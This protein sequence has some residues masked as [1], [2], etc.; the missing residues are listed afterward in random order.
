VVGRSILLFGGSGQVGLELRDLRWADDVTLVAP[1][2]TEADIT[3]GPTVSAL[4]A[5][6]PWTAV[7]NAAAWTAVDA[8][9][10]AAADAFAANAVGPAI[11]ADATRRHGVPL[12]H[13]S[14]DYVFDGRKSGAYE[15]DDRTAPLGVYGASKL[16]G[17][18]AVRTGNPRHVIV[19][20]AW[21]YGRYGKNFVR[22]MLRLAAER[23]TV[24]V[25]DDQ[26]GTPTLAADLAAAL[27]AIALRPDLGERSGVYHFANRGETTWCGLAR[28]AFALSAARGGP[29]AGV[30]PITTAEYPTPAR[31]PANSRLATGKIERELGIVPRRWEAALGELIV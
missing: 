24:R 6:G 27:A 18:E 1:S 2:R 7:I 30:E 10:D 22:T 19:R 3:D 26:H 12:I 4:V 21:V 15:E 11:L 16:A 14:T 23:D 29:S 13:V 8:A 25:V 9:E 5:D 28:E 17:E 20:T 31:R